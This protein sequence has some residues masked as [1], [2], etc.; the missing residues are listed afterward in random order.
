MMALRADEVIRTWFE[1]LWNQKREET[2]D[3]LLA[4]HGQVYGLPTPDHQPIRGPEGFKR[5]YATFCGT[6]PDIRVTV[7][8]TITEGSMV[9]AQCHVTGRHTGSALAPASGRS[10]EFSGMVIVRVEN[11]RIVE[12]WNSFDF[13]RLYQ[14]MG[15]LPPL[16]T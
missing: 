7:E 8:R 16:P 13:L 2:I 11:G 14:Q 15:L 3:R 1:Q 4:P 5:F 6:F 12:A 10:I 9:A